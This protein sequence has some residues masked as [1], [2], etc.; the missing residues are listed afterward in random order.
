MNNNVP[1]AYDSTTE[2]S[3]SLQ[4][5]VYRQKANAAIRKAVIRQMDLDI[6]Q[7][8]VQEMADKMEMVDQAR[9]E[10]LIQ[11]EQ[12]ASLA[13]DQFRRSRYL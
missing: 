1:K 2:Q 11:T 3:K 8:T 6:P 9:R 5:A 12:L 13:L 7:E 10:L 4:R